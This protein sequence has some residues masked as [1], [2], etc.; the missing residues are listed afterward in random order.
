[1]DKV[2]IHLENEPI[3]VKKLAF[4]NKFQYV[5]PQY[6]SMPFGKNWFMTARGA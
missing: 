5:I 2:D 3:R 1:M 6:R 4:S